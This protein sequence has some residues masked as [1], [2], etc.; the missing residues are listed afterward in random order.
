MRFRHSLH[1]RIIFAFCLFGVVLGTAYATA[2]YISL[3]LI[4]DHLIDNRLREELDYFTNHYKH[5]H[6]LPRS[7]SPY[8]SAHLGRE[9]MPLYLIELVEGLDEGLHEAYSGP[10][11]Y[12]I[13]VRKLPNEKY[14]YLIYEVSALEFTEKRKLN[15]G[16][17]LL[18]GVILITLLGW[19][20]GRLTSR[21]V[22]APV[23]HLSDQVNKSGPENLPTDL[24][25]DFIADE[26]GT[27]AAAL[28][29]SMKR[30]EDFVG[31]EH[32]FTRDA[33]HELRTPV[34]VIKGAV[35]ILRNK[36]GSD[37]E[38]VLRLLGRIQRQVTNMENIIEALLW[39]SR[40]EI[41]PD[42]MQTFS[43][44]PLVR[45]TVEENRLIIVG[46][47]ID[48]N[49]VAR[50]NPV[51]SVPAPLFQIALTNLIQNAVRYTSDGHITVYVHD[52]RVLVSDTGSGIKGSD[53][54]RITQ[55]HFRGTGSNGFGLGLSL[56]KR[57][58]VRFGWQFEI[59]SEVDCGTTVHMIFK[60]AG[61]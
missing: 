4:D 29:Q 60:P 58:C 56:V 43:V 8:I 24:S 27:L 23:I 51:L 19:W 30:I 13:A 20:I 14:L 42:N 7:T 21:K 49:L 39:L 54:D 2:V 17:V 32:Q 59:E 47:S 22:I 34:T 35:E 36:L 45:D 57:L 31:R 33:S 1:S 52:D 37:E 53:L 10:D 9:S 3:D 44:L 46:K 25:K 38:S 40:E 15:I 61:N 6:L 28:E 12:H 55:P 41:S 18:G 26:V 50:G 11:E 16:F 48:I 5:H